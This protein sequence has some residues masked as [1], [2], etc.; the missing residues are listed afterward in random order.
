MT[1]RKADFIII[2]TPFCRTRILEHDLMIYLITKNNT[3]N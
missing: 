3:K 1:F 2:K